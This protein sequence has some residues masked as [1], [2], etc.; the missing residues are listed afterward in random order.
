[1]RVAP[2]VL[3]LVGLSGS[4][5][6]QPC[7]PARATSA[8]EQAGV[9][10]QLFNNG[11]LFWRDGDSPRGYEV[12]NGSGVESVFTASLWV[13]GQS[14]GYDRFA[15]SRYGPYE[16]WPGPL[17]EDGSLPT[18]E[19]CAAYDR[20]WRVTLEDIARYNTTGE[21]APDLAEWPVEVGAPVVDGDGDPTNYDLAAGDRPAI[22]GDETAWWV[23]NDQGDVHEWSDLPAIGLEVRVTAFTVSEAYAA[24]LGL[25][26]EDAR[27]LHHATAYRYDLAYRGSEPLTNA[28]LGLWAD[29][30]LGYPEDDYVGSAPEQNLA[31]TY[32]GYPEDGS[33]TPTGVPLPDTVQT[34]GDRPPALGIRVIGGPAEKPLGGFIFNL[35]SRSSNGIQIG[36]VEAYQYLR[37][38]WRDGNPITYGGIGYQTG[39]PTP[40]MFPSLP[41]NYWSELNLDGRGTTTIPEDRDF[42]VSHGPFTFEPGDTATLTFAFPW[43]QSERGHLASVRELIGQTSPLVAAIVR[44]LEP[45]P[46]LATI[47]LAELPVPI[48]AEPTPPD[49]PE[50]DAVAVTV[51]PNPTTGDAILRLNLAE[52]AHVRLRVFDALGREVGI[53]VDET[54]PATEHRLGVPASGLPAGVY[55][56]RLDVTPEGLSPL[57]STGRFVIAR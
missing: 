30:D 17:P 20:I 55:V 15:G 38:L 11:A 32:N 3:V 21:A 14:G 51:Q 50:R 2:L 26:R 1:M 29:T 49:R 45:D 12:P 5:R 6:A 42:L 28:Y 47:T 33:V 7:E 18:P 41:P 43:A 36:G 46:D 10:A 54:L 16:F 27:R 24:R 4:V 34:Y 40:Y 9:R 23:M 25:S 22:L 44:S 53:P 37:G 13:A 52:P 8:L 48:P 56:Y 57:V 35:F 31:Y 19:S 39:D